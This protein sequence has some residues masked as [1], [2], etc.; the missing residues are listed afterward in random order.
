MSKNYLESIQLEKVNLKHIFY[1]LRTALAGKWIA[2]FNSI[3]PVALS[4]LL[5]IADNSVK[6][7][8]E[9]FIQ[10]KSEHDEHY[11]HPKNDKIST[12]I[13]DLV[14]SNEIIAP[15]LAVGQNISEKLNDFFIFEIKKE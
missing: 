11:L 12:Y 10:I 4:E 7:S 1:A 2:E 14:K 5:T 3:P 8:I 15:G 9:L 6:E 13:I